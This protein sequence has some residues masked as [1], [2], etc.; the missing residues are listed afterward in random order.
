MTRTDFAPSTALLTDKYE[1]TMLDAAL[2]S[3][4]AHKKAT[5]ELFTRRLPQGRSYGVVGGTGRALEAIKNFTFT[6]EQISYLARQGLSASALDYLAEYEFSGEVT[7]YHEGELFFPGSPVLT[8]HG[9]FAEAVLLETVLLSI[10]NHDSAVASA[11]SRMVTAAKGRPVFELGTRRTHDQAG[12]DA[13]RAA[14]VAGFTAT[15]NV[16]AGFRYGIPVVGTAAHA[17]TLAHETEEEAFAAQIE[18]LGADTTLLVDTYDTEQGI[19]NAVKAGAAS[20]RIDS[21]DLHDET[22]AA[23]ELLDSLGSDAT[24]VVSS[25]LDEYAIDELLDTNSPI[26]VFGVGTRVVTGSGHPTA[27][28]VY[29]LVEIEGKD[30][31]MRPV[32]KNSHG[33]TS[34]GGRK[35]AWRE[36]DSSGHAAKEVIAIRRNPAHNPGPTPSQR[37]LQETYILDGKHVHTPTLEDARTHHQ[38]VLRE[39]RDSAKVLNAIGPAVTINAPNGK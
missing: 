22:V 31:Q 2:T 25:D 19:R 15:A 39:L 17:F 1:F 21:G 30:G 9:T 28:M 34:V 11:A 37:P 36:Y 7:G 14:Y 20:I 27:G 8:V 29:K 3:G 23:R 16:E 24:I 38:N 18:A 4:V 13:A 33:K 10:M 6:D 12:V 35:L 26:D 32:A 5:F